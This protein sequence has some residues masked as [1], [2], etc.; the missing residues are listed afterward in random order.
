MIWEKTELPAEEVRELA[1]RCGLDLISA[2][3]LLRRGFSDG[4]SLRFLLDDDL[5][6]L[7]NPFLF[8]DMSRAVTR[9]E[10]ALEHG[11]SIVIFGDR[12][13]DG[14]TSTILLYQQLSSRGA[15]VR[16]QIPL[17]EED[18]GLTTAV[19]EQAAAEGC[20][21]L[22]AVDCGVSNAEEI[23]RAVELGIDTI[24]LDHHNP[25][26][27]L[28]PALAIVN[29]K[30]RNSP[31][32]F[33]ELAGC[34]VVLK[35]ILALALAR[36][37]LF[38]QP[39]WIL[40]IRPANAAYQLEAVRLVNLVAAERIVDILPPGMPGFRKSRIYQ[41]LAGKRVLVYDL[42][43]Q[44]RLLGE[45]S[46][47]PGFELEDIGPSLAP[48][49]ELDGTSPAGKS[50]AG[51]GQAD[52][53]LE[54]TSLLRIRESLPA[55]RHSPADE[56]GIL[57][58]LYIS[59]M[60]TR[61]RLAESIE[62]ALDLAALGTI[63]DL[64]PLVD[65]N[66]IIVR[67]GLALLARMRRPGLRELLVRQNLHGRRLTSKDLSWYVAPIL[68]SAGRLGEPERAAALLLAEEPREIEALL[69][70]VLELNAR[71][72]H[73]GDRL[74]DSCFGRAGRSL[75]RTGGKL[76]LV[77]DSDIP[78]GITGILAARLAGAF[79][80]PAVVVAVGGTKAVGSLRSPYPLDGFLE[81]FGELLA[82][83]GG[84]DRAA[85]FSLLPE[86]FPAFE[87]R[88]YRLAAGY[89]APAQEEATLRIDA[90]VPRQFLTPDL[91]RV[92]ERLEPYGEGFPPLTFMTRGLR[93]ESLEIVG[94][95]ERAH[96][97]M[98]LGGERYRWPALYWNAAEK[99]RTEFDLEDTVDVAYRL[100]RNYFRNT[101]TLQLS[102]VDLKR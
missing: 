29:P 50:P 61:Y 80:V 66:K 64:M 11:H 55:L 8:P 74:W 93:I 54:G 86:R 52:T 30:S 96:V 46:P 32:P 31:Y 9:I 95:R 84:H 45:I 21:L 79:R 40:H 16:W 10:Q 101:E 12:D 22:I 92:V 70:A 59:A 23:T 73:L 72:R 44:R 78:R 15:K 67:R 71:R 33:R 94:K 102:V 56:L 89:E 62:P 98:L 6:L 18:Y 91:I 34:G 13:V 26:E 57:V 76:L 97:K 24:V 53:C 35:V 14:I 65:E 63:A 100:G 20:Q 38:E 42:P 87:E 4:E 27:I 77:S 37:P 68:N 60:W 3:V 51:R 48:V 2:S 69:E 17:G 85:G 36:T 83:F 25:P 88:F 39:V 5:S 58:H 99:A 43:A 41:E 28:P 1:R 47:E 90:E 82:N 81:G 19:I 75:E 49:P 7:H